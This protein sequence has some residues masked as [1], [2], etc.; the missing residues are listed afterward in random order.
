MDFLSPILL[1]MQAAGMVF[2][3]FGNENQ[4]DIGRAGMRLEQ[5]AID[6]NISMTRLQAEDASLAAMQNLRK[7]LGSQA[8][9]FAANG[10]RGNPSFGTEAMHTFGQEEK[11]RRLNLMGRENEL[12]A[13]GIMSKLHQKGFEQ[14]LDQSFWNRAI[15]MLPVSGIVNKFSSG[16]RANS[17]RSN[18][19]QPSAPRNFGM[20]PY[21]G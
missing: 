19:S 15:N 5:A 20:T 12:R 18:F 10:G 17:A 2:D 6:A 14:G 1:S 8:A 21:R 7:T 9:Y 16:S 11:T 3:W 13:Q 4:K